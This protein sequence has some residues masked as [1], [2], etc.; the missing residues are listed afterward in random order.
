M[1]INHLPALPAG[2]EQNANDHQSRRADFKLI[3]F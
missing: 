2:E 1:A 3:V